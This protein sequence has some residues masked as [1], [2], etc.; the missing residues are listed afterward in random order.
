MKKLAFSEHGITVSD[1]K[2]KK[3]QDKRAG[4]ASA[5]LD[6][7]EVVAPKTMAEG[8]RGTPVYNAWKWAAPALLTASGGGIGAGIGALAGGS[9][10]RLKGAIIGGLLGGVLGGTGSIFA[11]DPIARWLAKKKI[12][13]MTGNKAEELPN[14]VRAVVKDGKYRTFK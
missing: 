1:E 10:R 8:Y 4:L 5:I 13:A 12:I 2:G 9:G 6:S 14:Y 3:E 7:M 11:T